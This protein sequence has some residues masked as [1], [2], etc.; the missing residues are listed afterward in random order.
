MKI[1]REQALKIVTDN[2][3]NKNLVNH[4]LCVEAA[5]R[6]LAKHFGADQDQWGMVGLLHDADWEV[7][8]DSIHNHTRDT[9]KWLKDHGEDDSEIIRAILAHNHTHNGEPPPETKLD[10]SLYCCDELTGF[11]VAV[12]LI[13]PDKKLSSVKVSSVLKRMK[14]KAFAAAVD[15]DQIALCEE[16][17]GIKLEDFVALVLDSMK[18]IAAD[19]GL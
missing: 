16:K 15:R 7:N 14:N 8:R 17:L 1:T 12:A 13:Y 2:I 19:I 4:C 18:P 6:G 9:I 3:P 11:I 10:W 5:M